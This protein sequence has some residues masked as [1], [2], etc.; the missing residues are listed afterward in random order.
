MEISKSEYE[1][2]RASLK[3]LVTYNSFKELCNEQQLEK[4]VDLIDIFDEYGYTFIKKLDCSSI[5]KDNFLQDLLVAS[6]KIIKNG[7]YSVST[8]D[9]Q[10]IAD[11]CLRFN[12]F[13]LLN[14]NDNEKLKLI[15]IKFDRQKLFFDKKIK[16]FEILI[17]GKKKEIE[18]KVNRIENMESSFGGLQQKISVSY[19]EYNKEIKEKQDRFEQEIKSQQEEFKKELT[20]QSD[21][22]QI[23]IV[24]RLKGIDDNVHREELAGYFLG[25]KEKLKGEVNMGSLCSLLVR[26]IIIITCLSFSTSI[27]EIVQSFF[28]DEIYK[29]AVPIVLCALGLTIL[30]GLLKGLLKSSDNENKFWLSTPYWGWLCA[31]IIGVCLIFAISTNIYLH[32][33]SVGY[34]DLIHRLPLFMILVWYTWFCAKQFSYYRQICDEY[35][36]KYLLSMSYLSYRN[37]AND[38]KGITGDGALLVTLLDSVIKNISRSPVQSIKSDC[39]TPLAEMANA[40]KLTFGKQNT[41]NSP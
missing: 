38:L 30:M 7:V 20:N 28:D 21:I 23:D 40:L 19:D 34:N 25:E 33:T 18:E 10:K 37:E 15:Q 9:L 12:N 4:L 8:E 2:I 11:Y 26:L 41:N 5:A 35:E 13:I 14:L 22:F 27:T 17:E 32:C 36:Y 31:T 39:Y 6:E 16:D 29:K 24:K 3:S 1:N